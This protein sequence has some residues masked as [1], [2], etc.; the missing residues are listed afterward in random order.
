MTRYATHLDPRKTPQHEPIP[1]TAQVRNSSAG[2]SWAVDDWVRL[3][4]FLIL[5]CEGG[6]YYATE[7][8]L[9]IENAQAVLRCADADAARTVGRIVAISEAGRAPKND[10][11]VFALAL[12][13]GHAQAKGLAL[14]ALPRV[15]R[16]GTHLFQFADAVQTFRGWGRAL[17]RAIG[18]W[19]LEKA[20]RDLAYQVTKYQAREKWTHRDLLRLAHPQADGSLQ[21][22]LHWAVKGWPGVGE[23]PHSEKGLLPIWAMEKAK[24]AT[25]K[26]EIVRLI[27]DFRLVRECIPTQWLNDPTVWDALLKEMP[28]TALVRNLA[29]MTRVGLLTA[30]SQATRAVIDTLGDAAERLK[31]SRVHPVAVLAAL[32]TYK[33]GKSVRGKNTWTPVTRIIDALDGA[34][35]LS[36]GNVAPT[37]KRWLLALDVSGSMN[38]GVVA[39][40]PGLTPR[41]ASSALALVTAAVEPSHRF[42]AFT[43]TGWQS[44]AAGKGQWASMGYH[45]GI[46]ELTISP[47][48]RLDDVCAKTAILPMGGTDCALPML[49]AIENRL[50]VDVFV[51]LTDSETW[52]GAVHPAQA[53]QQYRQKTGIPAKLIV[54]GMVSNSFSIADP[55]DAGMLDVVGFDTA[56]PQ[57]MSEFARE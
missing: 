3:D 18:Q 48:Q 2:Y 8:K 16:I 52:A 1:G 49:Y 44:S 27:R 57:L 23:E 17:R 11:A 14:A 15:C 12:L 51:V 26:E 34:F 38:G 7:R 53:L 33:S 45:N 30:T 13:S 46:T 37:G 32:L 31:K 29:T 22:I 9:T 47:R 41:V 4:R 10:A 24:H 55:E 35:Y 20:P 21:D 5:G 42:V 19:Y 6:S 50:D 36:F 25:T 56:T 40:V 43:S 39:G 28:L 54:V